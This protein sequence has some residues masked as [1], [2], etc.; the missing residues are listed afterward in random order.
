MGTQLYLKDDKTYDRSCTK[1]S[2]GHCLFNSK[3]S[4]WPNLEVTATAA[5]N[6]DR[7]LQTVTNVVKSATAQ[8]IAVADLAYASTGKNRCQLCREYLQS[9]W[10]DHVYHMQS[11]YTMGVAQDTVAE[12]HLFAAL[13]GAPCSPT[14]LCDVALANPKNTTADWRNDS[15]HIAT[16]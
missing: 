9:I 12:D 14:C 15:M 7:G 3:Y 16:G 13:K 10:S 1:S 2:T 5:S 4:R 11:C 8:A 6:L